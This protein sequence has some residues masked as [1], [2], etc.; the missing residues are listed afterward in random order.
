MRV[1]EVHSLLTI[2]PP[3][4][5]IPVRHSGSF[6]WFESYQAASRA[7]LLLSPSQSGPKLWPVSIRAGQFG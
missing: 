4:W 6:P 1:A 3:R 5:K 2:D 7:R